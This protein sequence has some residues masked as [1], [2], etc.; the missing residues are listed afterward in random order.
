MINSDLNVALPFSD[1][2]QEMEFFAAKLEEQKVL[3]AKD[4]YNLN[5]VQS[6]ISDHLITSENN[7]VVNAPA[8]TGKTFTALAAI[9]N[10]ISYGHNTVLYVASN[11]HSAESVTELAIKMGLKAP[12]ILK[13]E[14][15]QI[16]LRTYGRKPNFTTIP[17]KIAHRIDESISNQEWKKIL[18]EIESKIVNL[19]LETIKKLSY[20]PNN[21]ISDR[22]FRKEFGIDWID[23]ELLRCVSFDRIFSAKS[24]QKIFQEDYSFTEQ[25]VKMQK[26]NMNHVKEQVQSQ[27]EEA[28]NDNRILIVD[29][30]RINDII[31]LKEDLFSLIVMDEAHAIS[32]VEAIPILARSNRFILFGDSKQIEP[33]TDHIGFKNKKSIYGKSVFNFIKYR[34]INPA[35]RKLFSMLL[36]MDTSNSAKN[37]N[38]HFHEVR[39]FSLTKHYRCLPHL[40]QF[41]SDRYY[42]STLEILTRRPIENSISN[43]THVNFDQLKEQ[44]INLIDKYSKSGT[45]GVYVA[46]NKKFVTDLTLAVYG[47][48]EIR[49]E[50]QLKIDTVDTFAGAE[51]DYV[52]FLILS[53]DDLES[54]FY[55]C[56]KR[57]NVMA[58]RGKYGMEIISAVPKKL[59]PDCEFKALITHIEQ[60]TEPPPEEPH[61]E[62]TRKVGEALRLSGFKI[63]YQIPIGEEKASIV[64]GDIDSTIIINTNLKNSIYNDMILSF[65]IFESRFENQTENIVEHITELIKIVDN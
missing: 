21:R 38:D 58:T 19:D 12:N 55:N 39:A 27:W 4:L 45:V 42:D 33:E 30:H 23:Q 57:V 5:D 22:K 9:A 11:E 53:E 50:A 49:E 43:F 31:P 40:I 61:D 32:M 44:V 56:P 26:T 63:S 60:I 18:T 8:G 7:I 46:D 29:K 47:N 24:S 25:A 65:D 2:R 35:D 64:L 51:R 20:R 37:T 36:G 17:L 48:L 3:T 62:W 34:T 10:Y 16:T 41:S 54:P 1:P 6:Q 59:I 28:V 14:M 13:T 15:P 52:I